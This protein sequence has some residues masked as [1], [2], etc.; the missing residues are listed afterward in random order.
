MTSGGNKVVL[1]SVLLNVLLGVGLALFIAFGRTKPIEKYE[2]E[3]A[4]LT[5][6]NEG[7]ETQN[8]RLFN[9]NVASNKREEI[10]DE[11]MLSLTEELA[12]GKSVIEYL[13]KLKENG[14]TDYVNELS[15]DAIPVEFTAYLKRRAG[16]GE[17]D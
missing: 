13:I 17:S 6:L 16:K 7:L 2:G 8:S 1:V 15:D 10:L 4:T 14:K 9:E 5:T 12:N 3:I 11:I